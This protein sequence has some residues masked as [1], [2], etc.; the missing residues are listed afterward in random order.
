MRKDITTVAVS[1]N[2]ARALNIMKNTNEYRSV[3]ALIQDLMDGKVSNLTITIPN[4]KTKEADNLKE[5]V[6]GL[7]D[8][9][10]QTS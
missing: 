8:T 2:M 5:N 4:D 3:K 7:Q 10:Q 6:Q 9:V 1:K